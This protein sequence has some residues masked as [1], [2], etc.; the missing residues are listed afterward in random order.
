MKRKNKKSCNRFDYGGIISQQISDLYKS[1]IGNGLPG[2]IEAGLTNNAFKEAKGLV[3]SAYNFNPVA[4]NNDELL[5]IYNTYKGLNKVELA[6]DITAKDSFRDLA[7]N[8][9]YETQV[10]GST[11]GSIGGP[12]GGL[13]G[14]LVGVGTGIA[15][16]GIQADAMN[17]NVR[18][19]NSY[20]DEQN[21][22]QSAANANAANNLATRQKLGF[23]AGYF[24][25]GGK[26]PKNPGPFDKDY[27]YLYQ[28]VAPNMPKNYPDNFKDRVKAQRAIDNYNYDFQRDNN[29][30]ALE[31]SKIYRFM[32]NIDNKYLNNLFIHPR[33][34]HPKN[35]HPKDTKDIKYFMDNI[36]LSDGGDINYFNNG[37][38]HEQNPYGGIPQGI[39]P[40]GLKNVVEEGEVKWESPDGD[41]IFSNNQRL[42]KQDIV[43]NLLP[44]NLT[45]KTIAE[46]AKKVLKES[47]ERPYDYISNNGKEHY[48]GILRDINE[49]KRP[50]NSEVNS[51]KKGGVPDVLNKKQKAMPLGPQYK[52]IRP[53]ALSIDGENAY[54]FVGSEA[55]GIGG[56]SGIRGKDYD[57]QHPENIKRTDGQ[58]I[59]GTK[60][61]VDSA[62]L[63][64]STVAR[65]NSSQRNKNV[66]GNNNT[67]PTNKENEP[68]NNDR[69][70]IDPKIIAKMDA[71]LGL[72]G[73]DWNGE[74]NKNKDKFAD[75]AYSGIG[76][77]SESAPT[78]TVTKSPYQYKG[79]SPK[80]FGFDANKIGNVFG[81]ISDVVSALAP[82]IA[83]AFDN[84]NYNFVNELRNSFKPVD[85][86]YVSSA[87]YMKYT[88]VDLDYILNQIN[89][90]SV[91][92]TR[93][94]M[95]LSGGNRA[96]AM[97]GLFGNDLNTQTAR[98]NAM[99][100]ADLQNMQNYQNVQK[101][102]TGINEF[103]INQY[104]TNAR[105][106]AQGLAQA[107]QAAAMLGQQEFD[108]WKDR[109][110]ANFSQA[111]NNLQG[112]K[113][114]RWTN[115]QIQMLVNSGAIAWDPRTGQYIIKNS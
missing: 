86:P 20:I 113:K 6:S 45:N 23:E 79:E 36:E 81:N 115:D 13:I 74:F 98:G 91:A 69:S 83:A 59:N 11:G 108:A 111:L 8:I 70:S 40:N 82:A 22:R 10:G 60:S 94:I 26:F 92:N 112:I 41:Y 3:D 88:P 93:N 55:G 48:L 106:N 32:D 39:A 24:R 37:G 42:N 29:R 99:L 90:Q 67:Q 58:I 4:S 100:Q 78:F 47:D 44:N 15:S 103:D 96:T 84:P 57:F 102:N 63:T 34:I 38:T 2:T 9:L 87:N 89:R 21:R 77:L 50:E 76:K 19:T 62:S 46:A 56:Y 75:K 109:E 66:A 5:D 95:D 49:A 28:T 51:F 35:L 107:R 7:K 64:A 114:D 97:A 105:F 25:D 85:T 73:K 54:K 43:D 104:T 110:Y 27:Y 14:T 12:I 16:A 71:M 68:A 18:M 61:I 33:Y 65:S 52:E 53:S 31:N 101:H 1:K 72:P 30:R 80:Q 17:S